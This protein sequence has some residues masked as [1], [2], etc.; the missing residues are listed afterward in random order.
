MRHPFILTTD[1]SDIGIGSVL[2]QK[3]NGEEKM[4]AYFSKIHSAAQ[5]NYSTTEQELLAVVKSVEHFSHYLVCQ[6]FI[7]NTDHKSLIYLLKNPSKNQRLFRWA[8]AL[9]EFNFEIMHVKDIENFSDLLSRGFSNITVNT[10]K[11]KR[12]IIIL[13]TW[14]IR[15]ILANTYH[16]TAHG[17]KDIMKYLIT[18]LY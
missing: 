13:R 10:I 7:L 11:G 5:K 12:D 3:I 9:Q 1:A 2:S 6:K 14:E 18:K 17:N 8:L 16:K 4:I 15:N